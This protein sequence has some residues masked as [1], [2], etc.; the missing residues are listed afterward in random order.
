MNTQMAASNSKFSASVKAQPE[1]ASW[2][3]VR[4]WPRHE[5]RV[6]TELQSKELEVFLPLMPVKRRWSDRSQTIQV[7]MFPSYLFVR[8][9]ETADKRVRVLSTSGVTNFV[10]VG[11]TGIPIPENEIESVRS[12]LARGIP[13]QAHPFLNVGQRV[14]V[15]GSS[16]DGLE[17]ILVAVNDDL[18]LIISIQLIQR[19]L[20]LR[21]SGYQVEAA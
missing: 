20:S 8:I 18:S 15:R 9:L 4:T 14:R 5:K 19:S 2:F 11:G 1:N 21:I 17:G 16:L 10:G 13:V 7:P 6:A 3:A 12:V